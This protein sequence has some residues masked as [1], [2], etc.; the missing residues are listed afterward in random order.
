MLRLRCRPARRALRR[1]DGTSA[2]RARRGT[3]RSVIIPSVPAATQPDGRVPVAREAH[4]DPVGARR[5]RRW[6][7]EPGPRA[8]ARR[9]A[10]RAGRRSGAA[11]APRR[12]SASASRRRAAAASARSRD[13][14]RLRLGAVVGRRVRRARRSARRG[15]AA[16][17]GR[18][19]GRGG[20]RAPRSAGSRPAGTSRARAG[21]P[22]AAG[23]RPPSGRP[24]RRPRRG[25]TASDARCEVPDRRRPVRARAR[26]GRRAAAVKLPT[27][28][29][30]F[31]DDREPERDDR[32][33]AAAASR[34]A[35]A[36]EHRERDGA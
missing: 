14:R 26:T 29:E 17:R 32:E 27:S 25:R 1:G 24:C 9:R 20:R 15:R 23:R 7:V 10:A 22:P 33:Q 13:E 21:C 36:D 16:S 6:T 5:A 3:A 2:S 28:G 18:P 12:R 31:H 8:A 34:A 30:T 19:S 11:K 4:R 35:S